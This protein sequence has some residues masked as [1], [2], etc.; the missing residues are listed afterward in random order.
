MVGLRV[1][2]G[3]CGEHAEA[4]QA[5]HAQVEQQHVDLVAVD[6]LKRLD[7]VARLGHHLDPVG[8]LQQAADAL[9]DK[10][11]VVGHAHPDHDVGRLAWSRKPAPGAVS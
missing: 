5:R 4:V 9:P 2:C 11:L 7:A 6:G 8:E 1:S 3:Q 10:G